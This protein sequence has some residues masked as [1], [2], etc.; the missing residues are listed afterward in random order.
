M[1]LKMPADQWVKCANCRELVYRK[2]FE[3]LLRVCPLCNYH[4]RLK[5]HERI[6]ITADEGSFKEADALIV[7][8]DPLGF[9]D[10]GDKLRG[11]QQQ[12]GMGEAVVTGAATID[13]YPVQL[14]VMDLHF[15]AGSM[16]A[17]VG[18]KIVRLFHRGIERHEPVVLFITSGGA[19]VQE[20]LHALMQ[21]A[22]TSSAVGRMRRV[23][24]PYVAVLTDPS[25]AGVLA[26]FGSLGDVILAEPGA[27]IGFTGPRVM[28]QTIRIKLPPGHQSAE[29]Q[30]DHGMVDMVVDRCKLRGVLRS[31]LRS[32]CGPRPEKERD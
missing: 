26:S 23:G 19:R 14:G 10:Y 6:A 3:K 31:L 25:M 13:S 29:F 27:V 5:A 28:E 21:M 24:V 4:Q 8:A 15:R 1:S 7:S 17:A 20:G 22:K 16:S 11:T 9:P 30:L 12:T 18:E 2:E 32:L